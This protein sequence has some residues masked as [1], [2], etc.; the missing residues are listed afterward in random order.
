MNYDYIRNSYQRLSRILRD[1]A[2]I[3]VLFSTGMRISELCSL[4]PEDVDLRD[5]VILISGKGSKER[6]IQIGSQRYPISS[7]FIRIIGLI[8]FLST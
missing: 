2:V 3:E 8:D 5:G 4:R 7:I 6:R 1:I